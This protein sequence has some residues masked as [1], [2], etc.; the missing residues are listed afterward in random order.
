MQSTIRAFA[1]LLFLVLAGCATAPEEPSD[2]TTEEEADSD[3]ETDDEGDDAETDEDDEE[4]AR[5][6]TAEECPP[7]CP[8]SRDAIEDS[9]SLLAERT[10]Y[11][12]FDSSS[13]EKKF[14][15]TIRRHAA[16]LSEYSDVDVRLEG[17]TDERGSREYNV[18]LGSR[19][20]EAVSR[21][22]KAY[23][24]SSG[25]I[26]TISYG[27]EVPA[28]EGDNE[29]AWEKNRRVEIVYP[30]SSDDSD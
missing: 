2:T 19:R 24:V 11:F 25:Q 15:D 8:F 21:L 7:D 3:T 27:E 16:Y 23:G 17:H 22:L 13:V 4:G 26:E 30:A 20:A 28:E 29:E 12:E 10:I 18:G 6:L 9:S 5:T 1:L 14:M